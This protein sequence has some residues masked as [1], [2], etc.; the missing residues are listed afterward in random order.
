MLGVLVC[1]AVGVMRGSEDEA[2]VLSE[3]QETGLRLLVQEDPTRW[4]TC[5]PQPL[6]LW[7]RAQE[8]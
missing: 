2:M 7:C 3:G 1:D 8:V 4:D 6:S 5:A